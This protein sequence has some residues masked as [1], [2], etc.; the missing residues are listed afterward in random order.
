MCSWLSRAVFHLGYPITHWVFI[1]QIWFC[2]LW[3]FLKYWKFDF[4]EKIGLS[5]TNRFQHFPFISFFSCSFSSWHNSLVV[6]EFIFR[7]R[8]GNAWEDL[9]WVIHD[10][11][12]GL[13]IGSMWGSISRMISTTTSIRIHHQSDQNR[14]LTIGHEY[15]RWSRD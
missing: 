8:E 15:E 5:D 2:D 9:A 11:V 12:G 6:L 14:T 10:H 13:L 1:F 7:E 4:F 3:T